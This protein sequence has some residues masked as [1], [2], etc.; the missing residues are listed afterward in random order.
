MLILW[1]KTTYA[2]IQNKKKSCARLLY[3]AGEERGES[4]WGIA[5]IFQ[6][7]KRLP[8]LSITLFS[9][10]IIIIHFSAALILHAAGNQP[11]PS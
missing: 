2:F 8:I 5:K 7:K 4:L 10:D 1:L 11:E 6:G 3:S 9:A